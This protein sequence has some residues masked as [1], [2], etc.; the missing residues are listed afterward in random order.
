[1][2]LAIPTMLSALQK[3]ITSSEGK[4]SLE[5]AVDQHALTGNHQILG[6]MNETDDRDNDK[7]LGHMFGQQKDQVVSQL[8]SESGLSV[9]TALELLKKYVPMILS[10]VAVKKAANDILGN[11]LDIGDI[12]GG[13]LSGFNQTKTNNKPDLLDTVSDAI[14]GFFK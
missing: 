12:I 10:A 13:L 6:L 5:K 14:G 8:D 2:Q 11:V 1:M 7:I 3:N 4:K 9:K